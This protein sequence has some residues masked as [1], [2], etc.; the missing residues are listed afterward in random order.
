LLAVS[1]PSVAQVAE[2][3][4][5]E[6]AIMDGQRQR[7]DHRR[8]RRKPRAERAP[9]PEPVRIAARRPNSPLLAKAPQRTVAA[10]AAPRKKVDVRLDEAPA[11]T[12]EEV[13]PKAAQES[14]RRSARII[15]LGGGAL[16]ERRREQQRLLGRLLSSE[17]RG[18]ISRAAD[19]FLRNGFELPEEQE[20]HLQLLEHFDESRA[21]ESLA[22]MSRLLKEQ[23]PIK[24]PVL[25][26]R[27]RRLEEYA[28]E[29]A[30]RTLAADLRRAIRP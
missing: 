18:A 28:D 17:G 7:S 25:D 14:P 8:G 13:R 24:R 29:A 9:L 27:L 16:D 1:G 5:A 4:V 12:L 6:A 10:S 11:K 22:T 15:T 21:R 2:R 23:Q 19:E 20:V 3:R 26:Q 30:T